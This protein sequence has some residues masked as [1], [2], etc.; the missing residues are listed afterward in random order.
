MSDIGLVYWEELGIW[1][2]RGKISI[3]WVMPDMGL[4]YWEES[5]NWF[6]RGIIIIIIIIIIIKNAAY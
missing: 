4:V 2:H 6:N 3:W 1:F 5:G